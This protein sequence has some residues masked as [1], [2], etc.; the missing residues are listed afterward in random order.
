M[1]HRRR[2]S[3]GKWSGSEKSFCIAS[4]CCQGWCYR[5]SDP[6]H[7]PRLTWPPRY[8][9]VRSGRQRSRTW[10]ERKREIS[11]EDMGEGLPSSSGAF[12]A[13][14][15]LYLRTTTACSRTSQ[16]PM[17]GFSLLSSSLVFSAPFRRKTQQMTSPPHCPPPRGRPE[18]PFRSTT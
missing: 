4:V 3:G 12:F 1:W 18:P 2:K 14:A 16:T 5:S 7:S 10:K 6:H 13:A 11:S 8:K 15:L 9:N 17:M